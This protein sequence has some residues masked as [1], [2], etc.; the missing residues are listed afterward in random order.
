MPIGYKY[1]FCERCMIVSLVKDPFLA[2]GHRPVYHVVAFVQLDVFVDRR[3]CCVGIVRFKRMLAP[4][5]TASSS[6]KDTLTK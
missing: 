5:Q 6:A 4:N 1:F 3:I 2:F